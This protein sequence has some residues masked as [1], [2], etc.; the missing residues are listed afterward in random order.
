MKSLDLIA[1]EKKELSL[2]LAQ[3]L[4]SDDENVAAEAFAKYADS[5]QQSMIEEAKNI[6]NSIDHEVM[7]ARGIRPLTGEETKFYQKAIGA[8]KSPTPQQALTNMEIAM[9]ETIIDSVFEDLRTAHPLLDEITFVNTA[10]KIKMIVNKT[11]VQ[12]ATWGP[13][14]SAIT[15]ELEGSIGEVNTGLKKLTAFIPVSNDMLDL[16]HLD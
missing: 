16:G 2:A 10:G 8:M 14:H 11:G 9:P 5:I 15:K 13:L 7:I 3:A 1:Q 12:L 4:Q 6:S